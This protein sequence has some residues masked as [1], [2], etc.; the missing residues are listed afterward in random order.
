MSSLDDR[1]SGE[2]TKYALDQQTMF[3]ATA[4]RNK[5]TGLWAAELLGLSGDDADAY[6]KSVV[7]ADLEEAGDE[8]VIRKILGDFEEKSVAKNRDDVVA[9]LAAQM[10]IAVEQIKTE[11]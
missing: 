1:K 3:K 11:G 2:E 7:I 9:Q 8:D 4:R 5:L 10:P 6:A